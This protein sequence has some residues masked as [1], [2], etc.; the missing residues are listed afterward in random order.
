MSLLCDCNFDSEFA[1]Y[2]DEKIH[3][4]DYLKNKSNY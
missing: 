3:I 1:Y 4:S 2:N